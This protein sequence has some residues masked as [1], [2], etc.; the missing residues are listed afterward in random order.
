[1]S[2]SPFEKELFT[3]S[4][5]ARSLAPGSAR[6]IAAL[7][8][9][10]S[11]I[12]GFGEES[13][14]SVRT[15]GKSMLNSERIEAKFG[16]YGIKVLE[17]TPLRVSMLYSSHGQK[18]VCRTLAIVSFTEPVPKVLEPS[19]TEIKA[20]ASLGAT[21]KEAG[22]KIGKQFLH[23][24]TISC[25]PRF[26]KL[27]QI[28]QAHELAISIY[29]LTASREG[30]NHDVA[31]VVEIHHPDYLTPAQLRELVPS[32]VLNEDNEL[33]A[34]M[35][36]VAASEMRDG[37]SSSTL[38]PTRGAQATPL[39]LPDLVFPPAPRIE[40]D[41]AGL[42]RARDRI[43]SGRKPFASYWRL[44]KAEAEKAL[45]LS[46]Q[47]IE[48]QDSLAFHGAVQAQG[49]AARLLA[50]R[51][52]LE[53]HQRSGEQAIALL[54]G[55]ASASPLPG[56]DLDPTIRY[57]NAG[58]DVARGMLPFVAAYDLLIG[59]PALTE[60]KQF[61]IEAWFR[62][63]VP[64]IRE[65]IHRWENNDDFGGQEFQ[66]HHVSHVLGLAL[67]GSVLEDRELI[68]LALD[69][70]EN[71]KDFRELLGGLILM[72][73]DQPHG[74]LRGKPLHPGEIQDRVRTNSGAGLTYCHL[75]LTLM[76]Y[77]SEVL[78]RAT[79]EDLVN[80]TAPG[81]ETLRLSAAFYSD[82]FRL[83]NARINGD[84][85]FR[86]QRA[87][88]NNQPFLGIFEVALGHWQ[89]V[90]NLKA[91]VRS[92]DRARTPRSWLNYYGLPLLTH[93]LDNP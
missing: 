85:Y 59:H 3:G 62:A 13:S 79:G 9:L 52:R 44:A 34:R 4:S 27:A 16:S 75:S 22:W 1:M 47:P 61:R 26:L 23:V 10:A 6:L 83:R 48:T 2:Y 90:P 54:D 41:A 55:W 49:I 74:G 11:A 63:L 68:R 32:P 58:M 82:F 81:G 84:Y 57:P 50:Y 67:L 15:V 38:A 66:N 91:V 45:S 86:D 77:A 69:S 20:G 80:A 40:T 21:L 89:D 12:L 64:V 33:V 46:P 37:H 8:V 18:E 30:M 78:S 72:P 28:E 35:L 71:P 5:S 24:G 7:L 25:G 56:T 87:I 39:P 14:S 70:P 29:R 42:V 76:L 51:W 31:T 53:D 36:E 19:M 65:G 88:Q 92:T 43:A 60:E 73:G 93:G 17:H